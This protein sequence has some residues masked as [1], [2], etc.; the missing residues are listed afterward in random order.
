MIIQSI[1]VGIVFGLVWGTLFSGR[2]KQLTNDPSQSAESKTSAWFLASTSVIRYLL[3]AAILIVLMVKYDLIITWWL[4]GF[5]G[6]FW[7]VLFRSFRE[8]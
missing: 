3:L 6:S 8:K 5:L 7:V 2:Y 4:G 1:V